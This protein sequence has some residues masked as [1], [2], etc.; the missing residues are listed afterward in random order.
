[1]AQLIGNRLNGKAMP[2]FRFHDKGMLA[3]IGRRRA[4]GEYGPFEFT[5]TLAWLA[6][7]F[8]HLLF[9]IEAQNRL[10]IVLQWAYAY[11][12]LNRG[13]R[14]ITGITGIEVGSSGRSRD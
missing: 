11:L 7:L 4:V 9:I 14:M 10:L 12:T 13:S 5:G 1:M 6:W 2:P 3:T 8:I